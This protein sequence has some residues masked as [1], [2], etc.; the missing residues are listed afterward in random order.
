MRSLNRMV[1]IW[2]FGS[3]KHSGR[4]LARLANTPGRRRPRLPLLGG[5][6]YLAP[7]RNT[8]VVRHSV[9]YNQLPK[10]TFRKSQK[11]PTKRWRQRRW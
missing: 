6:P 11:K 8:Q 4:L 2:I 5:A 7:G 3:S 1:T 10:G 9:R